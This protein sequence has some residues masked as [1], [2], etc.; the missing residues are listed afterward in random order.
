MPVAAHIDP[1]SRIVMFRCSGRV[2]I[3]EA[4]RAFDEMM[5]DP[6]ALPHSLAMWD[7]RGAQIT[8]R[9]V[10]VSEILDML[11]NRHPEKAERSRVAILV[12][13][14]VD[15]A[16]STTVAR[17]VAPQLRVKVFSDYASATRWLGGDDA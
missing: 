16:A 11:Q 2:M 13:D 12:A 3:N 10:S 9:S 7:F 15:A 1:A 17:S 4:R 5:T 8:E 14:E 6:S